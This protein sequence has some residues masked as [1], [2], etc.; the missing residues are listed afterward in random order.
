MRP[1]ELKN[2]FAP[3]KVDLKKDQ[4]M[5][6]DQHMKAEKL[7]KGSRFGKKWFPYSK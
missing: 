4:H 2:I 7:V 5:T 1:K 3:K 6:K